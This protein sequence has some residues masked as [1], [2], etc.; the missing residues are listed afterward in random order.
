MIDHF[1]VEVVFYEFLLFFVGSLLVGTFVDHQCF[2][3]DDII[4]IA[5]VDNIVDEIDNNM[6]DGVVDSMIE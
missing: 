6:I 5:V 3:S 2:D 1:V 4:L